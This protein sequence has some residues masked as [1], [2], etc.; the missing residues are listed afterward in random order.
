MK[1]LE[2][3]KRIRE[4]QKASCV[5]L[6][7]KGEVVISNDFGIKPLMIEL[8]EDKRA[9]VDA[10]IADRVVGKA[11]ALLGVL[12]GV[13]QMYGEIMSEAACKV[14]ED[15]HITYAYGRQ[16]PYIENRD[17]TGKCPMEETV[18]EIDDAHQAFDALEVTIARLMKWQKK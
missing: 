6:K 2:E 17:N 7:P 14:L 5:I 8:R 9:F 1:K 11:A 4:E 18:W 3:A 12:G 13:C 15:N 16:V 10:V